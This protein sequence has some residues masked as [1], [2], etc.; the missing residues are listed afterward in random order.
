MLNELFSSA[1]KA[2]AK[3]NQCGILLQ[4]FQQR[5]RRAELGSQLEEPWLRD[6]KDNKFFLIGGL[7]YHSEKHTN[8][9][10]AIDIDNISLILQ[11]CHDFPYMRHMSE[12]RT[13]KRVARTA[14]WPQVEQELSE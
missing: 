2:Y 6:Y 3:K 9:L 13:K 1:T 4:L 8:S 14:W 10:K 5:Y 11:E 7:L 12:D